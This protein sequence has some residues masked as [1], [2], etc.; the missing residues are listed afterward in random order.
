MGA[1]ASRTLFPPPPRLATRTFPPSPR[2]AQL[3]RL[4]LLFHSCTRFRS[5]ATPRTA[6][7]SF[8]YARSRFHRD[9]P[10]RGGSNPHPWGRAAHAELGEQSHSQKLHRHPHVTAIHPSP[11]TPSSPRCKQVSGHLRRRSA[12]MYSISLVRVRRS[13]ETPSCRS[14]R[15]GFLLHD[16]V[17]YGAAH[18]NQARS[19][20]HGRKWLKMRTVLSASAWAAR[21]LLVVRVRHRAA[22]ERA[23][24]P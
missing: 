8:V 7:I 1:P 15:G 14:L 2:A 19:R 11:A 9:Q 13:P 20:M 4:R 23:G 22:L 12:G 10:A 6:L 21:G 17:F 3:R 16:L 18:R 24:G 5:R